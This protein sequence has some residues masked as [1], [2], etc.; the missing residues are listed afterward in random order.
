MVF[1]LIEAAKPVSW[2]PFPILERWFM[3]SVFE[4]RNL[5][6]GKANF[7]ASKKVYAQGSRP[8]IQVPFR[9]VTLTPTAG[10]APL[11]LALVFLALVLIR[12]RRGE[13][14]TF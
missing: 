14:P 7:P 1:R 8:D 6:Q 2:R 4:T 10:G 3:T 9:Q 5:I 13:C 12:R 11:P